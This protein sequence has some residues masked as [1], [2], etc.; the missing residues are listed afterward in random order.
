MR[1]LWKLELFAL[2]SSFY[3]QIFKKKFGDSDKKAYLCSNKS[4]HASQRCVPRWD[5]AFYKGYMDYDKQ[6]I[7]VDEQVAL[8]QNRGL[9]IED[10]ATAKLQLRN[11]SYFRIASYLRYMEEDR[12]FSYI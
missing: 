1:F 9:V 5:F 6:P 10:I 11:I 12:Q 4:H 2:N 3:K 7:N 8:L